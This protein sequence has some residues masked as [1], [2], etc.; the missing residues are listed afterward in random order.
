MAKEGDNGGERRRGGLAL[1]VTPQHRRA[2]TLTVNYMITLQRAHIPQYL[3]LWHQGV[4]LLFVKVCVC[5]LSDCLPFSHRGLRTSDNNVVSKLKG[6]I[7]HT[8][9]NGPLSEE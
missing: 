4:K 8:A 6:E 3:L 7:K 9:Y 5:I 2:S 1:A